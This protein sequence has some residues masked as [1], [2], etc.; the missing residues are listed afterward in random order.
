[1]PEMF[2]Y[3]DDLGLSLPWLIGSGFQA[4]FQHESNGRGGDNSRSTNYAYIQPSFIFKFTR[5]LHLAISPKAWV[6]VRNEDEN[7]GDLADFRGYFDL[8]ARIGN[9]DGVALGSHFRHGRRGS[10]WQVDL[11]YPLNQIPGFK[12]MLDMYLHAQYYNGFSEQLL[13]YKQR[14]DIFRIGFSL[15]R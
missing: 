15:V 14:E 13:E 9:P 1:M 10:S 5:D 11:S 6:Y 4:G 8:A 3:D 2:Y 12:G 7:N